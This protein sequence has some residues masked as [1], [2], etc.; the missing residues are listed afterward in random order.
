M[1]KFILD[2]NNAG[3][4]FLDN[5]PRLSTIVADTLEEATSIAETYG[6]DFSDGCDGCCG[7]R[8][9]V[10]EY[11]QWIHGSDLPDFIESLLEPVG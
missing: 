10:A 8:W 9:F 5:F 3:G 7:N 11:D 6:V 1:T 2:Q 4:Y